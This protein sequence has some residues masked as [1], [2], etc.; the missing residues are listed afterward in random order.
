MSGNDPLARSFTSRSISVSGRRRRKESV[1]SSH[2]ARS[3]LS[4]AIEKE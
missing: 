1:D 2:F 3:I 4:V